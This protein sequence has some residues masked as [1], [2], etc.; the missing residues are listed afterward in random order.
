MVKDNPDLFKIVTPID[1]EAFCEKLQKHP[2]RPFVTSVLRGLIHGFW[3]FAEIPCDYPTTLDLHKNVPL[4][5]EKLE[6]YVKQCEKEFELGRFSKPFGKQLLPGMVCMPVFIIHRNGKFRMITDHSFGPYSLNSLIDKD[7]RSF[8]LASMQSFGRILRNAKKKANGRKIVIFKS[9]V[10][11]VY[12]RIP[13]HPLWQPLQATQLPDGQFVIN[14]NNVFG[15][16]ASGRCWWSVS[17]LMLWIAKNEYG[18]EDLSDYVDDI[19]GWDY[20]DNLEFYEKYGKWMPARQ[21]KLLRLWDELGIP[22]KEDK[23]LY[24]SKLDIIG[25]LVDTDKMSITMPDAAQ[26]NL[27]TAVTKFVAGKR[28]SH[29]LRECQQIAGHINWALNVAPRLRP[30]LASLYQ[31]MFPPNVKRY[32]PDRCVR[33]NEDIVRELHW[34]LRH[35]KAT[36]GLYLFQSIAWSPAEADI[37]FYTDAS[38]SGVGMWSPDLH[39]GYYADIN[40]RRNDSKIF[41]YEAYVVVCALHWASTRSPVPKRVAIFSDNTNTVDIFNSMR[42][43]GEFNEILKFAVDILM[44]HNIDLCVLHI[45]GTDNIIADHLSRGRLSDIKDIDDSL[46]LLAYTPPMD[47]PGVGIL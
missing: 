13:M 36:Q 38:L 44:R 21:V 39:T 1:P 5:E 34:F 43:R 41:Y 6:F 17:A 22:H 3:P 37:T 24:G 35:F 46:I 19:F 45:A 11:Q 20:A 2:N 42:A 15:G 30:G 32:N 23:Q 33:I 27:E 16:A 31:K 28:P 47:L 14:H 26:A 8:P 29:T 18:I 7:H 12:R 4:D 40:T 25:F 10:S 9:D